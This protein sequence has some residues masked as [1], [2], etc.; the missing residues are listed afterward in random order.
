MED[1]LLIKANKY[2]RE[3]EYKKAIDY[4]N[5]YIEE[6]N[7]ITKN[8]QIGFYNKAVCYMKLL[9][10][11]EAICFLKKSL[12]INP[13]HQKSLYNL[14]YCYYST[15]NNYKAYKYF[16]DAY[17]LDKTDKSCLLTINKIEKIHPNI[18]NKFRYTRDIRFQEFNL[19]KLSKTENLKIAIAKIEFQLEDALDNNDKNS[20]FKLSKKYNQLKILLLECK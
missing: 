12:K 17:E 11:S 2:Y 14:G 15:K 16:K 8:T 3:K 20:F 1:N 4:Y 6:N 10:Y 18:K 9:N 5:K 7:I 19:N 13:K